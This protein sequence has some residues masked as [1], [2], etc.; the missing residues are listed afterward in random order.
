MT[1]NPECAT[2]RKSARVKVRTSWSTQISLCSEHFLKRMAEEEL[3]EIV[4][5]PARG[6]DL[7]PEEVKK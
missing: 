1:R 5:L 2:C 7:L 3:S 6:A 4:F